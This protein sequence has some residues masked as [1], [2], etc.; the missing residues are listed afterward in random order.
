MIS[1]IFFTR[2]SRYNYLNNILGIPINFE[3]F[4]CKKHVYFRKMLN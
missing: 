4:F 1:S 3:G 2:I